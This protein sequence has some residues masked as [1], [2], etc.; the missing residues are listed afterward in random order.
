MLTLILDPLFIES[1]NLHEICSHVLLFPFL[2]FTSLLH[3]SFDFL[4]LEFLCWH[5]VYNTIDM[6]ALVFMLKKW[7]LNPSISLSGLKTPRESSS[8]RLIDDGKSL[9]HHEK[10]ATIEGVRDEN[11]LDTWTTRNIIQVPLPDDLYKQ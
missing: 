6:K 4:S 5:R 2:I 1:N 11:Q 10:L 7:R 3:L 8:Y 9:D